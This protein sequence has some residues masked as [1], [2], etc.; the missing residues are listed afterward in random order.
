LIG[1][2]LP[3]G[4]TIRMGPPPGPFRRAWLALLDAIYPAKQWDSTLFTITASHIYST[5]TLTDYPS[6]TDRPRHIRLS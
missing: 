3:I 6:F 4:A 5:M 1:E 2:P